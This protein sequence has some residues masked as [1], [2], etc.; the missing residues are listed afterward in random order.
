V[1]G[2]HD[3]GPQYKP[4]NAASTP[5]ETVQNPRH[6]ISAGGGSHCLSVDGFQASP[7]SPRAELLQ[8]VSSCR[9]G[10]R[11]A[12]VI[13][14]HEAREAPGQIVLIAGA[15]GQSGAIVDQ[16]RK[17][18]DVGDQEPDG[19][20]PAPPGLREERFRWNATG[21]RRSALLVGSSRPLRRPHGPRTSS[22]AA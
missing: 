10:E 22:A 2:A 16:L 17:P 11:C 6:S 12:E 19:P 7:V 21:R 20:P 14:A 18:A 1:D 3:D 4:G 13:V 9:F 5:I 15:E 8:G